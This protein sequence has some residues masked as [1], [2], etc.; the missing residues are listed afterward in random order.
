MYQVF[1]NQSSITFQQKETLDNLFLPYNNLIVSSVSQVLLIV[2]RLKDVNNSEHL[3]L[4]VSNLDLIWKELQE[5]VK[6]V[7]AAGGLVENNQ[8][9]W[10]FIF[11]NGKWDLPKGKLEAGEEIAEA[12]VREVEEECG[13]SEIKLGISLPTTFHIY[14]INGEVILKP[15]YWFKMSVHTTQILVPQEEEG[16]EVVEWIS[17]SQLDKVRG[18]TYSSILRLLDSVTS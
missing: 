15:T 3:I 7:V 11:R 9:E 10:L 1:I 8:G 2:N 5:N 13:L 17:H 16:I 12:A 4:H 14:W 18:N 6:I